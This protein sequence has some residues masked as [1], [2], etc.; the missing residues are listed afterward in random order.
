[1][2]EYVAIQHQRRRVAF[3]RSLGGQRSVRR[4]TGSCIDADQTGARLLDTCGQGADA[5]THAEAG[6]TS[7]TD[8]LF[9]QRQATHDMARAGVRASIGTDQQPAEGHVSRRNP[10]WATGPRSDDS[11]VPDASLPRSE[12]RRVG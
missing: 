8:P 11:T 9:G 2:V 5:R 7:V 10:E 4:T 3:P 6:L 1:L 12:E